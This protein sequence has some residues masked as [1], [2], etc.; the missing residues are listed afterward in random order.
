MLP[1]ISSTFEMVRKRTS[2]G[3][4]R[5]NKGE[6]IPITDLLYGKIQEFVD[7]SASQK[8]VAKDFGTSQGTITNILQKAQR[9][10][11][12]DLYVRVCAKLKLDTGAPLEQLIAIGGQL[13]ADDV[14]MLVTFA[15]NLRAKL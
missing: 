1:G 14:S 15:K 3:A 6:Q 4:Q 7:A 12:R 10:M 13:P 11:K 2:N 9:T 5:R 8:Q